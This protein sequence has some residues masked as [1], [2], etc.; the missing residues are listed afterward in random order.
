[1]TRKQRAEI[2]DRDR[3]E[4]LWDKVRPLPVAQRQSFLDAMT[5]DTALRKELESL[6]AGAER[7]ETFFDRFSAV[8]QEAAEAAAAA[9]AAKPAEPQYLPEP[10]EERAT[11]ADVAASEPV[12]PVVPVAAEAAAFISPHRISC[13]G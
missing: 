11:P 7:A 8:L 13:R 6:L 12:E 10:D 9:A 2:A 5:D 3:L 1:M 4:A